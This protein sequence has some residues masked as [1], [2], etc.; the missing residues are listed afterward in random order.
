MVEKAVKCSISHPA[1]GRWNLM[2]DK[3]DLESLKEIRLNFQ[4]VNFIR[5][6][7]GG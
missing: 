4:L 2:H 3:I 7:F 6:A 1:R 5:E